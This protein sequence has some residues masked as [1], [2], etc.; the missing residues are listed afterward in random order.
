[1]LEV[2]TGEDSYS[3][4]EVPALGT[5]SLKAHYVMRGHGT[6]EEQLKAF[7]Q[8]SGPGFHFSVTTSIQL[9]ETASAATAGA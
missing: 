8:G 1:M 5:L 6:F 2:H 3:L 7:K 4:S 9:P